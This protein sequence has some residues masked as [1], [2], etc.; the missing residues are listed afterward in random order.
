MQG[1]ISKNVDYSLHQKRL[2]NKFLIDQSQ[3]TASKDIIRKLR[4]EFTSLGEKLENEIS[5]IHS[6]EGLVNTEIEKAL[7]ERFGRVITTDQKAIEFTPQESHYSRGIA[8]ANKDT[9]YLYGNDLESIGN[10]LKEVKSG[11][12]VVE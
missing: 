3:S 2:I 8:M 1:K 12:R 5:Q 9:L 11:N 7:A 4:T 6:I 10:K